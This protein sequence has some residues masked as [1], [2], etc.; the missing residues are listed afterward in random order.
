MKY[1]LSILIPARNEMFISNTVEDILKNKRGSTEILVGL[2]GAWAEPKIVEHPDV[3]VVYVSESIGQRAMTNRLCQ[4]STAKYVA[5]ADAHTA[6]D[7]G[8]DVK[9]MEAIQ[10]H[11]N[12]TVVPT[13]RNLHAFDWKCMTC[14]KRTY[15]GPTPGTKGAKFSICADCGGNNFKRRLVWYPKPSPN[16]TAYC[17]DPTPHFQYF[18]EFKKRPEGQG[19]ITPTLSLQGSFFMLTREKYWELNIC[20]EAFGSWGSQGIEVACKTW[21]SGGEVMCVQ[22][23]W[24]GH[25]FRT[26]GGDFGFPYKHHQ[27]NIDKA[28]ERAKNLFLRNP[29]NTYT[30]DKQIRPLSWLIEKFWPITPFWTT[31]DLA[32]LK[33]QENVDY[34]SVNEAMPDTKGIIYYTDNQLPLK[35]ARTIQDNIR[36]IGLPIT[37]ASLK[38]MASMGK[39]IVVEGT[40]GYLTMFKQILAALEN[41]DQDI[42][43]FC[44]HDVLYPVSHFDFSPPRKDTFYYD[45]NWWKLRLADGFAVHWDADQVSGMCCYRDLAIEYYKKRIAE[46]DI[47]NFDR[48]FEPMSEEGAESYWSDEPHIDIRHNRNLTYNKWT[49]DDFRKKETAVNFET[50]TINEI[51]GWENLNKLI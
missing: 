13:M 11:D 3:R 45:Q 7:E 37:S 25:M 33:A 38:P 20:D 51:P 39:N 27:S 29:D 46:F 6:Y 35:I 18:N 21:L 5:K 8:F 28:R 30:W 14:G 34:I 41:C 48:K 22:S 2:D 47:N 32:M 9:L 40:R 16:S 10:G 36:S 50:T 43:Y 24:Y 1:D 17:F 15:Q 19:D 23:T 31:E 42:V 26:Q 44:E 49:L 12:W 4:I